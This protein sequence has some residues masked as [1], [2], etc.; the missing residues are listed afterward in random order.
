LSNT[1]VGGQVVC[2]DPAARAAGCVP[3]NIFGF[4][5]VSPAAATW[6]QTDP[7]TLI[8]PATGKLYPG[9]AKGQKVNYDYLA[10]VQQDVINFT[11]TG[12]LFSLPGGPLGIAA[13]LE[14]RHESSSEVFDPYT[15]FG[16]SSG[17]QISNTNGSFGVSEV[18]LELNAPILA[19]R[20]LI[21]ELSLEAAVRTANY[22]TV[23]TAWTYKFGGTYA[24]SS[25]IRFRAIYAQAVRAPNISEL[26][27]AQSQT[28]PSITDPCDQGGGN[29]DGAAITPLPAACAAIPGIVNY[30]KT[31]PNF[32]YSTAQIQTVDGLLGGNPDLKVEKTNTIT[33]GAVFTPQF[34]RGL[35]LTVD[36]YK[37]TVKNAIGIIGQQVSADECFRNAD[38]LFC[39]NVIRSP[40][41]GFITRVNALNLNVGS[42]KVSGLDIGAHYN[43]KLD[44]IKLPGTLDFNI[45]WNH[46]FAQ[47]QTPF[48]G[49]TV[50]NELG[51]L[52]CYSCGRLGTGFKNQFTFNA[53]YAGGPF[54]LNYRMK[55]LG[56]VADDVSAAPADQ[57]RVPAFIYHNI[58][59]SFNFGPERKFEIYVGVDNLFDKTP[60]IFGDTD[61]VTWPGTATI[62]DT[63]D[64]IGR[65]LYAGAR[66]KF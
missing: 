56:P 61:P 33:V 15:Q 43:L 32:A 31:H 50:Q 9:T 38:P 21:K 64:T 62:A 59:G 17:N 53:V 29:G 54:K 46:K 40:T 55:Y 51:Q 52:D 27:S 19:D 28:F 44:T 23:G 10:N 37:I 39:S 60:P 4:N 57:V 63:Y 18:F 66:I 26:F 42:Y 25:D 22:S 30:L 7:G 47:E 5:T 35:A 20:P 49:G 45:M 8:D 16:L 24:P 3:I 36:Y 13:G 34:A 2:S 58:Q 11:T 1:L 14:Y 48:P 12:S 65:M 41:T 6:L